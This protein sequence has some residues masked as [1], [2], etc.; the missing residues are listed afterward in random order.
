[1]VREIG[2]GPQNNVTR[3][4][5]LPKQKRKD[6]PCHEEFTQKRHVKSGR[7]RQRATEQSARDVAA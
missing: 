1:M 5:W 6:A 7:G 3:E 2:K 4:M